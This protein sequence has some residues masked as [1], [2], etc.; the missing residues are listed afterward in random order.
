MPR[1]FC[2]IYTHNNLTLSY[3][4]NYLTSPVES[5]TIM[6]VNEYLTSKF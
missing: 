5:G 3:V 6:S 1:C 2:Q 4:F